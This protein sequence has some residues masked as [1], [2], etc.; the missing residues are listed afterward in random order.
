MRSPTE[1]YQMM[2]TIGHFL[3]HLRPSQLRGLAL[4]AYGT[5]SAGSACQNAVIAALSNGDD[6]NSL[7]EYLRQWLRDGA[8]RARPCGVQL[9]VRLCF[10]PLMSWVIAW[11]QS[12]RL[13]LAIDPTM[14]G[15]K[16]ASI[17][18]SVLYRSCA[19]PV[20]WHILP[21]NRRGKWIEPTME[22]LD[23]LAPAVPSDKTVI[24]MCDRGLRSPGLYRRICAV[25]WHPYVRQSINTVFC[26]DGGTRIGARHLVP[27]PGH[28]WVGSGTAFSRPSIRRRCTL[29][30]VWEE[31]QREPQIVMTDLAPEQAGVCWYG[32]RFWIELGFKAIKSVGWQWQKT[33]RTDPERISRHWLVLSVATLLTLAYGSRVEDA[34]ARG[35][36]P[37][38]LRAPPKTRLHR[39]AER[40]NAE[41]SSAER[42]GERAPRRLVSV[43]RRGMYWLRRLLHKCRLWR[44]VWLLPEEWPQP[45]PDLKIIYHPHT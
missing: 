9:D 32:L 43:L 31:G 40:G 39:S 21:A 45:S 10:A 6:W 28:A 18:I 36:A 19:I 15:D 22:L 42:G 11:W 17:V 37:G 8:D 4:W 25:G 2:K 33:R 34:A 14:K 44:R 1:C 41:R 5:I 20:A 26:P 16:V 13:A 24:V 38:R 29:I 30:V 23:L 12:D 27:A 35:V 3:P 7:R